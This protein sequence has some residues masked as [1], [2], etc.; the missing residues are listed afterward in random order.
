MLRVLITNATLTQRAGSELYVRDLA[1]ALLERGHAPIAY[2]PVLG[3]L[4]AE[5]RADLPV[6]DDLSAVDT[7]P[8]II[9]GH[10]HPETMTALLRFPGVPAVYVCHGW[11]PWE[12]TPPR[13]PRIQ[14]YVAVSNPGRDRLLFEHG[15]PEDRVQTLFNFVDLARFRPREP[16]LP[17]RPRHAVFFSNHVSEDALRIVREACAQ[18]DLSLDTIGTATGT[19]S[20]RPEAVLGS[21]DLV[22]ATGRSA[23]EALAVGTS[24]VL[25]DGLTSSSGPMVTARDLARLRSL[26]LAG[27][28]VREPLRVETLVREIARYDRADAQEVSRRIRVEAG[29]DAAVDRLIA[30]YHEAI[31]AWQARGK[32]DEVAEWHAAAAYLRR[33]SSQ[34]KERDALQ[35]AHTDA[36]DTLA[37][38]RAACDVLESECRRLHDELAA[39]TTERRL[40]RTELDR[41]TREMATLH[42]TATLRLR[43]GLLR[44]PG[45]RGLAHWGIRTAARLLPRG[46]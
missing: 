35:A 27:R 14:R 37:R 31:A 11:R 39:A 23:L 19:G 16:P 8:D 5:L 44:V 32:D 34:L 42:R 21:Y 6:V 13:F 12:E 20:T 38:L 10:H 36:Q 30:L 28:A 24:V 40:A 25:C 2:S 22:F 3:E 45:V 4:A 29:C 41:V 7:P 17:V 1:L 46:S 9:H 26:N 15:I 43:N 18:A 33:V